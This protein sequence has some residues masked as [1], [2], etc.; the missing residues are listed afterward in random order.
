[1]TQ[2]AQNRP[3]EVVVLGAGVIG[4]TTAIAIQEKGDYNVTIVAEHL[5][6]DPKSIKYTSHW[7]GAHHIYNDTDNQLQ[8]ELEQKTFERFWELSEPGTP[9]AGLFLRLPQ[10][11]HFVDPRADDDLI[12]T[13][14][15][16][17]VLPKDRLEPGAIA[18]ATFTAINIDTPQYLLYLLSRFRAAGG[19]VIRASI[20]SLHQLIQPETLVYPLPGA[21]AL[22]TSA[23][24]PRPIKVDALIACVGIGARSLAGIDDKDVYPIRGQTVILRAPWVRL[25]T[26]VCGAEGAFSYIIPRASGE[27][28]V[29]GTREVDDWY[30]VPRPET[31]L[32]ILEDGLALCPDLAPPEVRAVRKP[33]ID[34][35]LPLVVDEG[36]GLRPARKGG[37]RLEVEVFS[38]KPTG[39]TL[40][41]VYNYGHGGYGFQT[42]WASAEKALGLLEQSLAN[43][44]NVA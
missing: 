5:P 23:E 41:V 44:K 26:T 34:D 16:Y 22:S 20:Q 12:K 24:V 42:S 36:C 15:D 7:A 33:T 25:G 31:K 40:P 27:V 17:E 35:V 21:T 9:T 1:M 37:I 39:E 28:I 10:I 14:P 6:S 19:T 13:L 11:D 4:L 32:K 43:L 8:R 30:P 2:E 18:G 38:R 3:R 29:G